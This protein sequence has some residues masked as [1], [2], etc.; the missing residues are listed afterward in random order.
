LICTRALVAGRYQ[1]TPGTSGTPPSEQ[2]AHL[3]GDDRSPANT[4]NKGWTS[5]REKLHTANGI[6]NG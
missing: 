5:T 3:L 6:R 2:I 4:D 1:G